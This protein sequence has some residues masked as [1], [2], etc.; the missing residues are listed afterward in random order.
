MGAKSGRRLGLARGK[1][2]ELKR[3]GMSMTNREMCNYFRDAIVVKS[4][5]LSG[6][7]EGNCMPMEFITQLGE[8]D[9][10]QFRDEFGKF[11]RRICGYM[12]TESLWGE[13]GK[14]DV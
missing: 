14:S 10:E 11:I 6:F 13:F 3:L 5:K 8:S 12:N 7:A 9:A 1:R 4:H 2:R